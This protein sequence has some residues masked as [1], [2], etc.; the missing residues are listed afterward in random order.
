MDLKDEIKMMGMSEEE[1]V[2]VEAAIGGEDGRQEE[3]QEEVSERETEGQEEVSPEESATPGAEK[4]MTPDERYAHIMSLYNEQSRELLDLRAGI[5][6]PQQAPAAPVVQPAP[7]APATTF[8]LDEET[9]TRA[10]IEDDMPAMKQVLLGV[11]NHVQ[12]MADPQ[13]L[14]E[15]LLMEMPGMARTIA[16]QRFTL[17]MAVKEFYDEN[18]DLKPYMPIVGNVVNQI[19]AKDPQLSLA[20]VLAKAEVETR[21]QLGLKKRI[22]S[23]DNAA[24]RGKPA[25]AG[26]TGTRKPGAPRIAGVREDIASMMKAG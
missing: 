8:Q 1:L 24:S 17:L 5:Q 21:K 3:V 19:T 7:V 16:D 2:T 25:F 12:Q 9:L 4:E 18:A 6:V 14:R 20:D 11:I 22:Q 15:A 13:R 26:S 10:L 23:A